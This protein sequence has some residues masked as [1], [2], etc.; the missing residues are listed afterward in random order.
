MTKYTRIE[1]AKLTGMYP[2]KDLDGQVNLYTEKPR[3]AIYDY[4]WVLSEK[5]DSMNITDRVIPDSMPW[6]MLVEPNEESK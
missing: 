1:W 6:D 4:K 2:E 3:I 5:G